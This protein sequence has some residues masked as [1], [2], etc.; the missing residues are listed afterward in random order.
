MAAPI[1]LVLVS[2]DTVVEGDFTGQSALGEQ[3]EGAVNGGV[4]D[5]GIFFLHEAM[6]FVGGEVVAGFEK[7]PQDGVALRRLLEANSLEVA[8]ENVLSFAH[9][10]AR[11][12][13]LIINALLE[14]ETSG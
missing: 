4:A 14:P 11:D 1:V 7:R 13:R 8:V 12:G 5:A 6:K 10:L 2:G 9:H 3:L